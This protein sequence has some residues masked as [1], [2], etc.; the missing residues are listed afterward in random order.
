MIIAFVYGVFWGSFLNVCIFRLPRGS[1]IVF[2]SS[3]CPVC[4]EPIRWWQNIPILSYLFLS[5]KCASC[6]SKISI[7]Y[8]LVE[9]ATG[10]MVVLLWHFDGPLFAPQLAFPET[11]TK[12]VI[13]F[14]CH[15]ILVSLL[16]VITMID[17]DYE[18]I[19]D[20]TIYLG[21]GVGLLCAALS[22]HLLAACVAAILGASFFYAITVVGEFV[23]L[24]EAMGL[25]DVKFALMLGAFLGINGLA[26]TIFLCFPIG[27]F[28]A[29][30]LIVLGL[31]GRK[32]YIPFG[33]AMAIAAFIAFL[34]GNSLLE[35]Y[36]NLRFRV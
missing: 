20:E 17:W 26:I 22:H 14:A 4:K 11:L 9:L 16:L 33:P 15:L 34:W 12:A 25:G 2:P 30:F 3:A 19:P 32:D 23:F 35:W 27:V 7:R 21:T 28:L 29:L 18:I 31:K 8:P 24:K 36:I 10:F 1:S 6:W 13:P 5:G